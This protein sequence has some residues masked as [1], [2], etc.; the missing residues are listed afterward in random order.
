IAKRNPA[1]ERDLQVVRG[2][3][4]R[5]LPAI[6]AVV[7]EARALPSEDLPVATDREQDPLPVTLTANVLSAVLGDLCAKMR[8]AQNLVANNSD[9]KALVRAKFV[10]TPPPE[11]S[12]LTH[13][14][15]REHILPELL[16]LLDGQR[17]LR[18]ADLTAA[19][20]FDYG[21]ASPIA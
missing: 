13:G 15:R 17:V 18:I 12:Q 5:D 19:G 6:V 10:G 20:P 21:D 3:P 8:L 2:L 9:V 11:D 14:W 16:A 7:A 1:R 4:K